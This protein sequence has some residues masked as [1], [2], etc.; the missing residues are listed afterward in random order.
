VAAPC[1]LA[2]VKRKDDLL[3][4]VVR[5]CELLPRETALEKKQ[6]EAAPKK[7]SGVSFRLSFTQPPHELD[8]DIFQHSRREN[9]PATQSG[10]P[11]NKSRGIEKAGDKYM[12]IITK[13]SKKTV[14]KKK[15]APK[16]KGKRKPAR[17]SA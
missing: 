9:Y 6:R 13:K 5:T 2:F 15:T 16:T 3:P 1:Y 14:S 4:V 17:K 12:A 10:K 7:T 11:V 8:D